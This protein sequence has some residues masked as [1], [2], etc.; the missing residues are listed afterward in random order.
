MFFHGKKWGFPLVKATV[1]NEPSRAE[2]SIKNSK[3]FI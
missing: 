2:P 3:L 1:V